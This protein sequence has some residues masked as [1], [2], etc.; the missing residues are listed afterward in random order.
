MSEIDEP[1]LGDLFT[2]TADKVS[3]PPGLEVRIRALMTDQP[4]AWC[5]W[6]FSATYMSFGCRR[7]INGFRH[8]L[9]DSPRRVAGTGGG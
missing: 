8:A 3:T 5:V 7:C 1:A 6:I 2:S 4:Y 9:C